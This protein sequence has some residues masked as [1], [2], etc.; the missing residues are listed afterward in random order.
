MM[1]KIKERAINIIGM[2]T[3]WGRLVLFFG[4]TFFLYIVS[5]STLLSAP[6]VS[7]YSRLHVPSPSIGLTR[8]YWLLIHGDYDGAWNVNKLIYI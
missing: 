7:I 8:A 4:V 1:N 5:Y 2:Q 3:P 6:T